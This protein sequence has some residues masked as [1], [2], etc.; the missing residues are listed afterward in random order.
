MFIEWYS[1]MGVL[2]SHQCAGKRLLHGGWTVIPN[3]LAKFTLVIAS[4]TSSREGNSITWEVTK[5]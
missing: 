2:E 3:Q 4:S 1:G 5:L